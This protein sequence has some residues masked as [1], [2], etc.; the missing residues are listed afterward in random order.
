M[1]IAKHGRQNADL[2]DHCGK[3]TLNRPPPP[4]PTASRQT[5]RRKLFMIE[6]PVINRSCDFSKSANWASIQS[7]N[8]SVAVVGNRC[9]NSCQ[10]VTATP[11]VGG[12]LPFGSLE[13]V[14]RGSSG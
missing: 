12:D 5:Y 6:R 3:A 13:V 7:L 2:S 8:R 10:W 11:M 9:D 4:K 14:I 1:V